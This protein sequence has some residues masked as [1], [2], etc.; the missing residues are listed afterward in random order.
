ME[1]N[2]PNYCANNMAMRLYSHMSSVQGLD[3]SVSHSSAAQWPVRRRFTS[4]ASDAAPRSFPTRA[5]IPDFIREERSHDEDDYPGKGGANGD[6]SGA[7]PSQIKEMNMMKKALA[8]IYSS[9]S[10]SET[11]GKMLLGKIE[12]QM[13]E[14]SVSRTDDEAGKDDAIIDWKLAFDYFDHRRLVTFGVVKGFL[15]RVH[16]FPLAYAIEA[17]N[18]EAS[19]NASR[20]KESI[21]SNDVGSDNHEDDSSNNSSERRFSVVA[22]EAVVAARKM[23]MDEMSVSLSSPLVQGIVH[24]SLVKRGEMLSNKKEIHLRSKRRLLG[25]IALAMDGT[26]CDDELSCMFERPIEKLI[27]M[28]LATGRW[29]VISVFSCTD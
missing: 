14:A 13:N 4:D 3:L 9:C 26:R 18:D 28:L 2:S 7:D 21:A 17:D 27:E 6:Q 1:G 19:T 8:Q 23:T 12:A 20:R 29:D 16:Q 5:E 25:R 24:P 11:F 22:E 15:R 10:R